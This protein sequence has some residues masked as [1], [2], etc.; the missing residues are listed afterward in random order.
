M[1]KMKYLLMALACLMSSNAMAGDNPIPVEKLP[2]AAKAF[3]QANFKGQKIV[4]AEKDWNSFDCLLADGTKIEFDKKGDWQSVDRDRTA[5]PA[6]I[7]PKT[8][9]E[10]VK[11]NFPNCVVTQ[12]EKERY[13]FDVEFVNDI[14]LRFNKQGKFLGMKR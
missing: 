1:K 6:A 7:V 4:F 13:G 11:A 12:I 10:Y 2:Q 3:V 14:T 9:Q 8:I 5:V